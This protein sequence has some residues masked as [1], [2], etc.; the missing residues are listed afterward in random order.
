MCIICRQGP[1]R[2]PE[3]SGDL[4]LGFSSLEGEWAGLRSETWNKGAMPY[5]AG[6]YRQYVT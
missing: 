3:G 6:S 4:L 1:H 5:V 2:S